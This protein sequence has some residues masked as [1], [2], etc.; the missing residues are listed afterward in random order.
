VRQTADA[1]I[2]G[3]GIVGA[4]VAFHLAARGLK[5][6]ALLEKEIM[7][8]MGSSAASAGV[9]YHHLPEKVNL[10]LSHKSL[11]AVFEFEDEFGA[12][13]D[14]RQNG[15]IQTASAP[16]DMAALEGIHR[17]LDRLGVRAKMLEPRELTDIFP[18]MFVDDLAGAIH[19]PDDGYFDPHGMLQAY[20]ATA[21]TMGAR[22]MTQTPAIGLIVNGGRIAGVNTPDGDIETEIVVNAAGPAA[23][24]I[25][26]LA[27]ALDLPVKPF[28]RQIFITAPMDVISP[29]APFYFDKT[30]SFYFRPESG[31]ALMSV[32][33]LEETPSGAPKFDWSSAPALA[34]RAVRRYPA[35]DS[36]EIMRGWAGLRSMTPDNTA[37]LGPVPE[38]AGFYCAV[39]FSGHGVMHAPM[40]G[41][42][43]AAMIVDNNCE[44]F[45]DI[46]LAPLRFDRFLSE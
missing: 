13:I 8:G 4:S 40:T 16:E 7:L 30:P 38:P 27:G 29:D 24:G 2:I 23:A 33:D 17:E 42:I 35:F 31:G 28:K 10:Q 21:K 6:V 43:L 1:V 26:G 41:K 44:I 45:E 18:G 34:E 22:I 37:I 12:E 14:F 11:R 19:T 20:A 5:N 9:I 3:G 32:A 46:D 25:A 36:I 15:C 39:G